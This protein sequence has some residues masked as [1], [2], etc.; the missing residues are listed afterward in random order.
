MIKPPDGK[1]IAVLAALLFFAVSAA[2]SMGVVF[3]GI[4]ILNGGETRP[5]PTTPT[6][7]TTTAGA[8][9][10]TGAKKPAAAG[11]KTTVKADGSHVIYLT[12]DD[13]PGP[14]TEKLLGI[15]DQ[16]DV[17]ATFFVT[18]VRPKY[19]TCIA[20]EVRAGHAVGVHSFSHEYRKIYRSEAAYWSDFNRMNDIIKK[21]TGK[22]VTL[23]RFPGGSSN[24]VSRN[25]K[26]GIMKRL[27]K[28]A[29][30]KGLTYVDWNVYD[31]DAGET[32]SPHQV[33]K[34]II[35]GV[36]GRKKSIVLCHDVKSY[37]VNAMDRTIRWCLA[38]GYTFKVL[39]PG[40]FTV[41]H[42]VNN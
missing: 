30:A 36:K 33:Y 14:Y 9:K 8:K 2:V 18:N 19:Q 22:P 3:H 38:H 41:H 25:Y 24:T 26:E 34:N 32:T 40:G 16:Y 42:G 29:D 10:T 4:H 35:R 37:T 13:G 23:L 5:K 1:T 28:Q 31:G 20:K 21:Q 39:E 15:L 12:F 11:E 17:K 6:V 27:A 7:R